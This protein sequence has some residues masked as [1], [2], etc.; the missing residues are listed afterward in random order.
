MKNKAVAW[1]LTFVM[2]FALLGGFMT[3]RAQAPLFTDVA[4]QDSF[5]FD[6]VQR[7]GGLNVIEGT[8][9]LYNPEVV[10]SRGSFIAITARIMG[11]S[12]GTAAWTS[13]DPYMDFA[14]TAGWIAAG[15]TRAGDR[16][17]RQEA[18]QILVRAMGLEPDVTHGLNHFADH[19]SIGA[20]YRGYVATVNRLGIMLGVGDGT[21]FGPERLLN[22]GQMAV[23]FDRAIEVL[24]GREPLPSRV[25]GNVVVNAP[26][27]FD[28]SEISGNLVVA[29]GVGTGAVTLHNINVLGDLI[30]RAG[31]RN[32][33]QV[34]GSSQ[35]NNVVVNRGEASVAIRVGAGAAV[36]SVS[37]SSGDV[38]IAG[39]GEHS[40][41]IP[42]IQVVS[43]A[44]G[45]T[46]VTIDERVTA[47][48][49]QII[50]DEVIVVVEGTVGALTVEGG[51][52]VHVTVSETAEVINLT[53]GEGTRAASINVEGRVRGIRSSGDET[54]VFVDEDAS[55]MSLD[56]QGEQ[57]AVTVA[58]TVETVH[59]TGGGVVMNVTDTAA[60]E[61]LTFEGT[62]AD[63]IIAGTIEQL[64][65]DGAYTLIEVAET[66]VLIL[67]VINA[68]GVDVAGEGT[69]TNLA[70]GEEATDFTNAATVVNEV[71][72]D[73]AIHAAPP[74]PELP[75]VPVFVEP[76]PE[77]APAPEPE[78]EPTAAPTASPSPAPP[79]PPPVVIPPV[80]PGPGPVTPTPP[81]TWNWNST[82][83]A[84]PVLGTPAATALGIHGTV[85]VIGEAV[86]LIMIEIPAAPVAGPTR[87]CAQTGAY[88]TS[89][90]NRYQFLIDGQVRNVPNTDRHVVGDVVQYRIALDISN[91]AATLPDIAAA[92]TVRTSS[93]TQN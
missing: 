48:E 70:L 39:I 67:A 6:A 42:S 66:A 5:Y 50:G 64:N 57:A 49:V 41:V 76:E 34:T 87:Q 52:W 86:A 61:Q 1:I 71:E 9:G 82:V 31:S 45:G 90:A 7:W 47:Q 69:I 93:A 22:R 88:T 4:N 40:P 18:A 14:V 85:M 15:D 38:V 80:D 92:V 58:G 77:P 27:R 84:A 13:W 44:V 30:V 74:P 33:I 26:G 19:A 2:A 3:T 73:E 68:E 16:I 55:V 24:A 89:G 78:P 53:V 46:T 23:I 60:V 36:A 32:S 29:E 20:G 8:G 37:I 62:G 81:T 63:V 91:R 43:T 35:I 56:I 10:P 12:R 51:E 72:F 25:P 17:T 21:Q 59:V 75:E 11:F 65:V 79:P 54:R 83:A 28:D